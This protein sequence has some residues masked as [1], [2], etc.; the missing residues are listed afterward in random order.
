M[1][2]AS[3]SSTNRALGCTSSRVPASISLIAMAARSVPTARYS[4]LNCSLMSRNASSC[5][6]TSGTGSK[7]A[8]LITLGNVTGNGL[9]AM[10]FAPSVAAAAGWLVGAVVGAT[11][12]GMFVGPSTGCVAGLTLAASGLSSSKSKM[13]FCVVGGASANPIA[14]TANNIA[15]AKHIADE[16]SMLVF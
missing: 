14:L 5:A 2:R 4:V 8:A 12:I 7:T 15:A 10:A 16:R 9:A 11:A 3:R 6:L 13:L 1:S